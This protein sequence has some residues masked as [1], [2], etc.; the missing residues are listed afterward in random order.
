MAGQPNAQCGVEQVVVA[1]NWVV[2]NPTQGY[3]G[4][5]AERRHRVCGVWSV[6][7]V[8]R[9]HLNGVGGTR[10]GGGGV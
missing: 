1:A 4:G 7:R 2:C 5:G 3:S 10:G 9:P 6:G 8:I